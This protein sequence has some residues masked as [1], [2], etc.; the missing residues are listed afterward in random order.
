MIFIVQRKVQT[1]SDY[2]LAWAFGSREELFAFFHE[3]CH[4]QLEHGLSQYGMFHVQSETEEYRVSVAVKP[5][6][7]H[8]K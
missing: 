4:E 6:Y 5:F 1:G 8:M 3:G 2:C 7:M